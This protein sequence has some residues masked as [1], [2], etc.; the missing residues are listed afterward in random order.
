[1]DFLETFAATPS[2]SSIKVA[3]A[4][5]I[6]DVEQAFARVPLDFDV[7]MKL[8]LV[9]GRTGQV[10]KLDRALFGVK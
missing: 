9:C 4:I 8:P 6:L 2:L 7:Y 5:A 10:V 1:M 3:S